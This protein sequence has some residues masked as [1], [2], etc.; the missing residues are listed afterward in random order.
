V[1][2]LDNPIDDDNV[3]FFI[4]VEALH[5]APDVPAVQKFDDYSDDEQQ[6]PTS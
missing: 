6:S 1:D 2:V 5:S 3:E 4:V